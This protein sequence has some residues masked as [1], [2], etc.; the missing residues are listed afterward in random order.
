MGYRKGT[1]EEEFRNS[2]RFFF[3]GEKKMEKNG[4]R[5]MQKMVS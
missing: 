4:K 1:F 2:F 3:C 5:K